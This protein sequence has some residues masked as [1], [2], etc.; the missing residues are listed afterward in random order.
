MNHR[1]AG[2]LLIYLLYW[3]VLFLLLYVYGMVRNLRLDFLFISYNQNSIQFHGCI[4]K[5]TLPSAQFHKS[6]SKVYMLRISVPSSSSY[7]LF[8]EIQWVE[9]D[10]KWH[11]ILLTCFCLY[12]Q[13]SVLRSD[14]FGSLSHKSMQHNTVNENLFVWLALFLFY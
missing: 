9:P 1:Y 12:F 13:F 2:F 8:L 14:K 10:H 6:T 7:S 11:C 4:A 3:F 5:P